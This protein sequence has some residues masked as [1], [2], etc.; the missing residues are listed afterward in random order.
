MNAHGHKIHI[1]YLSAAF[2]AVVATVLRTLC[3]GLGFDRDIG[4]YARGAAMP[5]FLHVLEAVTVVC[6][7]TLFFFVPR[8]AMPAE[9]PTAPSRTRR[10]VPALVALLFALNFV[11][12][13][14]VNTGHGLPTALFVC[15]VLFIPAAVAFFLLPI[16]GLARRRDLTVTLGILSVFGVVCLVAVTY[17]DA[18]TPMNAPHKT[19]LHL[20]FVPVLFYLLYTLRDAAGAPMPR[21]KAVASMTAFFAAFTV[22]VS[23]LLAY[24]M[25]AFKDPAYLAQDLL[26]IGIAVWI[27]VSTAAEAL[28]LAASDEKEKEK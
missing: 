26:L 13:C 5:V 7:F 12:F 23:D 15:G 27:G 28:A 6:F 2:L 17:F 14:R 3:L 22:G 10:I 24:P 11:A 4:Y 18:Y 20:S 9:K 21:A 1:Y 8:E 16:L 25:G 19:G